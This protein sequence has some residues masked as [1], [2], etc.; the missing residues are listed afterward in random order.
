MLAAQ[1]S[2]AAIN[3]ERQEN[4]NQTAHRLTGISFGAVRKFWSHTEP[5]PVTNGSKTIGRG[6]SNAKMDAQAI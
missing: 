2:C 6:I 1:A 3:R 4:L 5:S